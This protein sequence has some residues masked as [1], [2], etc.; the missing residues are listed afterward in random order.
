MQPS[1]GPA[2]RP[3]P[4]ALA[5]A[6]LAAALWPAAAG[7]DRGGSVPSSPSGAAAFPAKTPAEEAADHHNRGLALRD[8]AW[9]L[10]REAA[11]ADAGDQEKLAGKIEKLYNRAVA[12]FRTATQ[13]NPRLHQAW[14]GLGYALRKSGDYTGSLMAYDTALALAP[15]YL[16]AIEYRAEAYLGLGRLDDAKASYQKLA[17]ADREMA[18]KLLQAMQEWVAARRATPGGVD[19]GEVERFAAWLAEAAAAKTAAAPSPAAAGW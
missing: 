1:P 15:N 6:L 17:A 14:S 13:K 8:K 5:L 16:E 7:A 19:P 12:E 10:E 2:L 11:T 18:G 4:S 3:L 9:K